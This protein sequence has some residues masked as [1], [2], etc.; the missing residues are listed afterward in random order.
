[1]TF[2]RFNEIQSNLIH[3]ECAFGHFKMLDDY[4]YI[5]S[6]MRELSIHYDT[7]THIEQECQN[8]LKT[9]QSV[10]ARFDAES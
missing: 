4:R 10:I 2:E 6:L 1:M 7:N 3:L 8:Y 5:H 9:H